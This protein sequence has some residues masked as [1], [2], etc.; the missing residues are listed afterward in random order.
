MSAKTF[1]ESQAGAWGREYAAKGPLWRGTARFDFDIAQGSRVLELGCGNGKT[2][3]AIVNKCGSV[4]A[5]DVSG[6]AV[7]L[8]AKLAEDSGWKGVSVMQA[9]ACALPFTDESFDAVVAFHILGHLLA[10]DRETAVSEIRRVLKPRG[11]VFVNAFGV[12]DMRFGRGKEVEPA[13]FQRGSG[14]ICHYF[15]ESELDG[16]FKGFR[17]KKAAAERR[18]VRYDASV[19]MRETLLREFERC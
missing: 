2:L 19:F 14:V 15:S 18:A 7:G 16:L 12:N 10:H 17:I 13:T 8:C 4:A 5:V 1:R 6:K 9:D 11:S 3:S